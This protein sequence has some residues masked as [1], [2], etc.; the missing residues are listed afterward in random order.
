MGANDNGLEL[1]LEA[2]RD[3]SDSNRKAMESVNAL[4]VGA[5]QTKA[6][7]DAAIRSAK[8]AADRL[9]SGITDIN[10]KISD[11]YASIEEKIKSFS[12]NNNSVISKLEERLRIVEQGH[13]ESRVIPPSEL[14]KKVTD[15]AQK[16][17]GLNGR[18]VTISAV[19]GAVVSVIISLIAKYIMQVGH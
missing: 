11:S 16:H 7:H 8:E 17:E 14:N 10:K 5:A 13:A 9:V 4:Q 6:E 3:V 15:L 18:F 2:L 19:S 12:E 1:V